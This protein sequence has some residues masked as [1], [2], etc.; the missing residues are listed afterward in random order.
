MVLCMWE[1]ECAAM[2]RFLSFFLL[3]KCRHLLLR[4]LSP[5]TYVDG[6]RLLC[7]RFIPPSANIYRY[8]HSHAIPD[9]LAVC[10]NICRI[11][12]ALHYTPF[13]ASTTLLYTFSHCYQRHTVLI[14]L[15]LLARY[16]V[17]LFVNVEDSLNYVLYVDS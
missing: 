3:R 16:H 8:T 15:L 7:S 10:T 4:R 6:T 14:V 1:L 12:T 13:P 5:A 9:F 2:I 17:Q 11:W